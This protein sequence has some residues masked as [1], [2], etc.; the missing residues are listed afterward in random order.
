[1]GFRSQP[2]AVEPAHT[3]QPQSPPADYAATVQAALR[4]HLSKKVWVQTIPSKQ[5]G[6]IQKHVLPDNLANSPIIAGIDL[7][8]FGSAKDAI[9]VTPTQLVAKEFDN[10]IIL[11]LAAIRVV[12]DPGL[13]GGHVDIEVDRLGTMRIP[14]GIDLEPILAL[15]RAIVHVNTQAGISGPGPV[16]GPGGGAHDK[17][18]A[19]ASLLLSGQYQ[20]SIDS[21]LQIAQAHPEHTGTCY[22]QIGAG[23]FF[24]Q[25]Y[26]RAIEYYQAA[27]QYGADPAMMDENIAEARAAEH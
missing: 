22:G 23:L 7:T 24:M 21:Y 4:P 5:L 25:Q 2:A 10:R 13:L 17:I 18:N 19:A 27:K 1:M 3:Q 12:H 8:T 14:V 26:G 20:A 16:P 6:N 11:D 9:V 15:L